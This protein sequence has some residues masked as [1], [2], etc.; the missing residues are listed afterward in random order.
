[1]KGIGFLLVIAGIVF[2][3][4]AFQFDTSVEVP[5][6]GLYGVPARVNNLGKMA[7]RQ[8]YIMVAGVVAVIG[9][10]FMGFGTLRSS[11]GD[12]DSRLCP[13]CAERILKAAKVCRHCGRDM[14][15]YSKPELA[16]LEERL[17]V[18][19]VEESGSAFRAGIQEFDVLRTYAGIQIFS[20]E[21]LRKAMAILN[22]EMIEITVY[23]GGRIIEL[24]LLPGNIGI[25]VD[26]VDFDSED[27]LALQAS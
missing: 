24:S 9:A 22:T 19:D 13:H 5:G 17:M 27:C 4:F 3:G 18:V 8:T 6:G 1:M 2:G 26:E 12:I 16:K 11:R 21:E 14:P 23:R 10:I 7:E 25:T 15:T 20:D